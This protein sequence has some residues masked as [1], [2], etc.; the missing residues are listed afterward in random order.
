[1][2]TAT[3]KIITA[4]GCSPRTANVTLADA[5]THVA[6]R[7]QFAAEAMILLAYAECDD[8]AECDPL[9]WKFS[10]PIEGSKSEFVFS[11]KEISDIEHEDAGMI[12]RIDVVDA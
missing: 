2:T 3:I 11:E 8:V 12:M 4:D 6:A 5:S 9:A 7:D 1:M 10:D